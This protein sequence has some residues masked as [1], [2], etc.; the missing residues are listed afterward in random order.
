MSRASE[1][2]AQVAAEI[3]AVVEQSTSELQGLDSAQV[4]HKPSPGKWSIQEILGHLIDSATNNHQRFVRAQLRPDLMFP[5]YEQDP[6]V[7][8]Q[9]YNEAGW[10]EVL[11]LWRFYNL[12][13]AHVIRKVPA[14][15]LGVPCVI[16]DDEAVTLQFLIEDYLVHMK[17]HLEQIRK[18]V[19]AAGAQ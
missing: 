4:T 7:G 10:Q 12:H 16:G 5:K 3:T 9:R 13:L 17:H 18:H 2:T 11:G 6:W 1:I 8:C 15:A 19:G 14:D